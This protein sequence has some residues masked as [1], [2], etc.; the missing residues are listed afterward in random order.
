MSIWPFFLDHFV[1]LPHTLVQ[2]YTLTDILKEETP[3]LWLEK[4]DFIRQH[5]G[6][7]L[8]NS[9]PDYLK[10][11]SRFNIYSRFLQTMRDKENYW[12]ALPREIAQWWKQR[13]ISQELSEISLH[14]GKIYITPQSNSQA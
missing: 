13:S 9:H 2:D 8:L 4:V 1:E 14:E 7:A 12:H 10:V 6:M 5:Y 3:R 11:P